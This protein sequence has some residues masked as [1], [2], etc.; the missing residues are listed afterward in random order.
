MSA[1]F[2]D[3][4]RCNLCLVGPS[5]VP[6]STAIPAAAAQEENYDHYDEYRFHVSSYECSP[7]RVAPNVTHSN[8]KPTQGAPLALQWSDLICRST[9]AAGIAVR[10][11]G[12]GSGD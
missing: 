6:A 2:D 10:L 7:M 4:F 9:L 12:V 1:G 8:A 3:L 11:G 5:L